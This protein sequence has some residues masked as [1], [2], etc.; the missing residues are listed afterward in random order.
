MVP[1]NACVWNNL[2]RAMQG[3]VRSSSDVAAHELALIGQVRTA[4]NRNEEIAHFL[5]CRLACNLKVLDE[6][7]L[8]CW[9]VDC[10]GILALRYWW[11]K[12]VELHLRTDVRCSLL[13]TPSNLNLCA[14]MKTNL[15]THVSKCHHAKFYHSRILLTGAATG[16]VC[17]FE[18]CLFF[19]SA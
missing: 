16:T 4:D 2:L 6:Q 7:H 11:V 12:C 17:E 3:A 13:A 15:C 5:W 8:C 1:T 18:C 9:C 19:N 14:G 10:G